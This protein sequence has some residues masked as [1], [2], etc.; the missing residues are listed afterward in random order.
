MVIAVM[1]QPSLPAFVMPAWVQL[2]LVIGVLGVSGWLGK[3]LPKHPKMQN[4]TVACALIFVLTMTL[5]QAPQLQARLHAVMME[6]V[7]YW[8][9]ESWCCYF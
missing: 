3:V 9:W 1:F 7:C 6:C 4:L 5:V 2:G 8:G